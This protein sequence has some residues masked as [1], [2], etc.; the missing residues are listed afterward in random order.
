MRKFYPWY[1]AGEPVPAAEVSRL[2]VVEDLDEALA[3]LRGAARA[4]LAT[5][6]GLN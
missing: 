5:T 1:L 4:S 6:P 3:A 2:L